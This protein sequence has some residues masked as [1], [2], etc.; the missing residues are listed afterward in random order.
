MQDL[1][2]LLRRKRL[3]EKIDAVLQP[4]VSDGDFGAVA[5]GVNHLQFWILLQKP[6][7]QINSRHAARHDQVGQQQSDFLVVPFPNLQ[8]FGGAGGFECAITKLEQG[9]MH[10]GAQKAVV[11]HQ[12]DG[13]IVATQGDEFGRLRFLLG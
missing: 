9:V 1:R 8:G 4:Q 2:E 7:A 6:F 3:G 11:L 13:F 5:A 10:G 12:Q